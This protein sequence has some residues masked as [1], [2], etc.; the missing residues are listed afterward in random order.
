[1]IKMDYPSLSLSLESI[2][3]AFKVKQPRPNIKIEGR[4]KRDFQF[5][6]G[7][8]RDC[9]KGGGKFW[10]SR[11]GTEGTCQKCDFKIL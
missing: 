8:I 3:N 10:Q 2:Q 1:M 11:E 4:Q 7:T 6:D 5:K 9:E